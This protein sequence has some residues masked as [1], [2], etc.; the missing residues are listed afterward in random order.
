MNPTAL[1][2]LISNLAEQVFTLQRDN[3]LLR[4][5]NEHLRTVPA[6]RDVEGEDDS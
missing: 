6:E 2:T 1:L 4:T 5:E 3:E